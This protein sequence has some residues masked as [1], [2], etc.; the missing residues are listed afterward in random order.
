M[1][2]IISFLFSSF[3]FLGFGQLDTA[4]I[5][6]VDDV[7][8]NLTDSTGS[9][10]QDT[11]L[12]VEIFVNDFDFFGE[13]IVTIKDQPTQYPLLMVKKTKAD[14]VASGSYNAT[15]ERITLQLPLYDFTNPLDIQVVVRNY[16]GANLPLLNTTFSN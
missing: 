16:Q 4:T 2:L 5:V 15:N 14:I 8:I 1:K 7:V 12:Q 11:V 6:S 9:V 10:Y 13:L 3:I